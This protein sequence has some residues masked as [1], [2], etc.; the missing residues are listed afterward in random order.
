MADISYTRKFAHTDWID[1]ESIVQA[2]GDNG[3]NVRFHGCEQEFDT[4]STT[5][6]AVNTA[7]KN[8]QQLQ[9]L[10]AQANVAVPANSSSGEFDVETYDRGLLP[11]NIDK[12]YFCVILP[13][14]GINVVH[15]FLYHVIPGN[16]VHVT[17]AFYNPTATLVSFG[18]HILA[19]GG[20]SS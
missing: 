3:V 9:F 10:T 6:G 1:G 18:Y 12:L 16:K 19:L 13:A 14:A 5:F 7:I 8:V 4:I 11:A 20:A 2:S 17:V 15:T